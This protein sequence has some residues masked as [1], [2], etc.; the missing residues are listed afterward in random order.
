MIGILRLPAIF[1]AG[2]LLTVTAPAIAAENTVEVNV[3]GGVVHKIHGVDSIGRQLF[4]MDRGSGGIY[5][6]K[7]LNC[8]W[9]RNTSIVPMPGLKEDPKNP[10]H[11]NPAWL[12]SH[13]PT[14]GTSGK[15]P[16]INSIEMFM[17]CPS[18]DTPLCLQPFSGREGS[19]GACKAWAEVAAQVVASELQPCDDGGNPATMFEMGNEMMYPWIK[20]PHFQLDSTRFSP[21]SYGTNDAKAYRQ[22]VYYTAKAIKERTPNA[23]ILGRRRYGL[24]GFQLVGVEKLGQASSG[25]VYAVHRLLRHP[26]VRRGPNGNRPRSRT[27]SRLYGQEVR[28]AAQ[29]TDHRKRP[30]V[31]RP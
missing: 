13:F 3:S 5:G 8:Q 17:P 29:H 22:W 21:A 25:S 16:E 14:K 11:P 4:G 12:A 19:V 31:Q 1:A 2:L 15:R 24:G 7:E 6:W 23:K 9:F 18:S 20:S 26:L 27:C 10:E 28:Q 30:G